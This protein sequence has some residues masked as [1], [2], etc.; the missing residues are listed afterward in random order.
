MNKSMFGT[1]GVMSAQSGLQLDLNKVIEEAASISGNMRA[2]FGGSTEAIAKAVFQA[3][4]LG[5]N[6]S[7]NG[8]DI[9]KFIR[10]PIFY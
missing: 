3:K 4:L 10:F 1:L 5:L 2:N 7:S 6:M 8:R 9:W